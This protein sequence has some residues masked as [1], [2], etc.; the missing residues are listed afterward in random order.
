MVFPQLR[1]FPRSATNSS[2]DA[3]FIIPA[4]QGFPDLPAGKSAEGTI[5]LAIDCEAL[6]LN[7]DGSFFIS[8]E[9]GRIPPH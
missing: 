9:Y 8:D 6:I 2:L 5:K 3:K 4:A 7:N 1:I